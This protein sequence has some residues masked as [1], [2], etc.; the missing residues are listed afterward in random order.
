MESTE[1][2]IKP[3]RRIAAALGFFVPMVGMLYVAR[4]GW[5]AIYLVLS[6]ALG[7]VDFFVLREPTWAVGAALLLISAVC[8][9]QAFRLARDF[10]EVKR[11]WY[12]RGPGLVFVIAAFVVLAL[13]IRACLVEPFRIPSASMR[14]AMEPGARLIVKKWGYGNYRAFGIHFARAPLSS[15]LS[16]G[17]IVVFESPQDRSVD[18]AKR[19]V[20]LPGDRIAYFS[21]RLWVN[22]QEVP[23]KQIGDYVYPD[24]FH[25]SPQYLERLDGGEYAILV[26]AEGAPF[27]P[28]AKT[29]PLEDRCTFTREGISCRVPE[30]H[31]FVLGDNR[32]NSADSRVWGFIPAEN[33]VGKVLLIIP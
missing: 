15:G 9:V 26:E 18:Y 33:I 20:G 1:A 32:D 6:L 11:P 27:V 17:D 31:Y 24:R 22:D 25:R 21:R 19:I 4:P 5:A 8:A 23:R 29:F 10:R 2:Y 28:P 12:S 14:P 13:G 7:V 3:S 30:G 16:R